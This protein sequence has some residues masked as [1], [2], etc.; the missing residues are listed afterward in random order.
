MA[1][2]FHWFRDV[3]ET[4]LTML[5]WLLVSAAAWLWIWFCGWIERV[6]PWSRLNYQRHRR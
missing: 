5:E 3:A 2:L 1:E 6:S 4:R